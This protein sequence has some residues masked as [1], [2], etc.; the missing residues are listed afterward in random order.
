[1]IGNLYIK[2]LLQFAAGVGFVDHHRG[3]ESLVRNQ[4]LRTVGIAQHNKTRGDFGNITGKVIDRQTVVHTDRAVAQNDKAGNIVA[5]HFLQTETDTDTQR[6]AEHRQYR[7]INPHQRQRNQDRQNHHHRFDDFGQNHGQVIVQAAFLQTLADKTRQPRRAYHQKPDPQNPVQNHQQT[8]F[9]RTDREADAVENLQNLIVQARQPKHEAYPQ[10]HGYRFFQP[11][12]QF[13]LRQSSMN[14]RHADPNQNHPAR[15]QNQQMQPYRA[16]LR[17]VAD[18]QSRRAE[19][20]HQH[21]PQNP[22]AD[23]PQ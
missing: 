23:M 12:G 7:Q 3:N 9:A 8:Q 13:V 16:K 17:Q 6:T 19:N 1:M 5:R 4:R 18:K 14:N 10:N 22:P 20:H 11:V 21:R 2:R 15:R